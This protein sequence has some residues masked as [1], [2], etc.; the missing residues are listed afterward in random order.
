M[1]ARV[2]LNSNALFCALPPETQ[3][4]ITAK[5]EC[6]QLERNA[7]LHQPNQPIRW[8][9]FPIDALI[10]TV[11]R[12]ESGALS[13][14]TLQGRDTLIGLLPLLSG[15]HFSGEAWVLSKGA[16]FRLDKTLLADYCSQ[17]AAQKILLR[18]VQALLT[19][20]SYTAVCNRHH[21]IEQHFYR[22]LLMCLDRL[23]NP[24]LVMTQEFIASMLGVRR[25]GI[26]EAAGRLQKMGIIQYT[27]GHI[28]VLDRAKLERLGCECYHQLKRETAQLIPS[29]SPCQ[30]AASQSRYR[31]TAAW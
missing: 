25:E 21:A 2:S 7:I 26:T 6:V 1:M 16:A 8:V 27:R 29:P 31:V 5:A 13:E 11:Y 9:Y 30:P 22:W 28:Q 24:H 19:Q 18:A 3:Q 20:A 23:Q 15:C 12:V 14:V 4:K 10:A 17:G